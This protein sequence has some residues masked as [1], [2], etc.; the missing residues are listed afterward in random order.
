MQYGVHAGDEG[1]AGAVAAAAEQGLSE[2]Q[3]PVSWGHTPPE[4]QVGG[5]HRSD[6]R[7]EV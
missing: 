4:G 1:G 2:G 3:Q 6:F 5:P 7:Q